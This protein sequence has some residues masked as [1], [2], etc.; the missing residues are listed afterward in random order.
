MHKLQYLRAVLYLVSSCGCNPLFLYEYIYIYNDIIYK[1]EQP[2][3]PPSTILPSIYPAILTCFCSLHW[4]PKSTPLNLMSPSTIDPRS[5]AQMT[6]TREALAHKLPARV[7]CT[8]R[9]PQVW[10]IQTWIRVVVN[11]NESPEN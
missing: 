9:Q 2:K 10:E 7:R 11:L 1:L 5:W 3:Y 6:Y 8:D 4:H